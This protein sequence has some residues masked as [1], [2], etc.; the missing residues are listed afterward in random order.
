MDRGRAERGVSIGLK[1]KKRT[2]KEEEEKQHMAPNRA[3]FK[4]N[5][6]R[7]FAVSVVARFQSG[8]KSGAGGKRKQ[9]RGRKRRC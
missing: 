1:A 8:S 9:W 6:G 5:F 7:N 3:S 4:V 2:T